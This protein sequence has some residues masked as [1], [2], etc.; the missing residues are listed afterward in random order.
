MIDQGFKKTFTNESWIK[1][2]LDVSLLRIAYGLV[3]GRK[4]IR[5]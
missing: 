2:G 4:K 5:V 3:I 1:L